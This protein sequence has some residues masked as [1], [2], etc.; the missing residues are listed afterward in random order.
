M[1]NDRDM[2]RTFVKD[3][4]WFHT[5][6]GLIGNGSFV[7]GSVF[8]LFE[9]LQRAGVWLFIVGSAGMLIDSLGNAIAKVEA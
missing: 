5:V 2:I 9:D 1:S 4:P 6:I 7:I 8:F 3:N